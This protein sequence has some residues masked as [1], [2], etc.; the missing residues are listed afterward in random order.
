MFSEECPG[1]WVEE[2]GL[3]LYKN[4]PRASSVAELRAIHEAEWSNFRGHSTEV[5][6]LQAS[7]ECTSG[8]IARGFAIDVEH[9]AEICLKQFD[10]CKYLMYNPGTGACFQETTQS[11][12]C[13]EGLATSIFNFYEIRETPYRSVEDYL[14]QR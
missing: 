4:K 8:N 12:T 11:S 9:C 2:S 1:G 13:T 5:D 3:N 10:D 6:V 7:K 14:A